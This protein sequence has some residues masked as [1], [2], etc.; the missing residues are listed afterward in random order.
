MKYSVRKAVDT[1]VFDI[2]DIC[3]AVLKES[4]TYSR[5]RFDKMK[6]S[7]YIYGA[8]MEQSG[9]WLRIIADE[10]NRP[11]GGLCCHCEETL[12]GPDKIATDVTIM[13][14]ED[15]RGRCLKQII[16][17]VKEYK[18]WATEQGAVVIKMGVSSGINI[19]KASVFFESLGFKRIG[20]MHGYVLGE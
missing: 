13:I 18:Q 1:E 4:P 16:Q 8:I 7:N 12:Y 14:S 11:I 5:T 6:T 19:D 17:M 20:A 15:V 10:N 3:E 9:W 2:A